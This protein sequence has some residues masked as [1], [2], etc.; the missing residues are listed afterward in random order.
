MSKSAGSSATSQ[1]GTTIPNLRLRST[2][3]TV[4]TEQ[5]VTA[6][7]VY[8]DLA[9][10]RAEIRTLKDSLRLARAQRDRWR[11]EAKAWKWGALNAP[12][13]ERGEPAK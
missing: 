4:G 10:A 3:G 2:S 12:K 13:H 1:A 5:Q 7:D 8:Q 11:G 6:L 9:A